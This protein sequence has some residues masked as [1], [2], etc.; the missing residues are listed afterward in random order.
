MSPVS[1]ASRGESIYL[2]VDEFIAP[3]A[4]TLDTEETPLKSD[5]EFTALHTMCPVLAITNVEPDSTPKLPTI[6]APLPQIA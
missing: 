3:R 4:H 1:R 2:S 6:V 5:L